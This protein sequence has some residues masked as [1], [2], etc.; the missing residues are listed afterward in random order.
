MING[1][2]VDNRSVAIDDAVVVMVVAMMYEVLPR[3][4][5]YN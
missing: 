5:E 1:H 2:T 4:I 3:S